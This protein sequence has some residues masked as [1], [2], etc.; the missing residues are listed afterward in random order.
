[1]T[2][3]H[4]LTR[5]RDI[6][7]WVSDRHGIPAIA[8]VRNQFGEERAQLKLSFQKRKKHI[9]SQD[10][11]MSP[12]SWTAWLAEL[13]RQQLALKVDPAADDFELVERRDAN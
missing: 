4:T 9:E 11:G 6:Q 3:L 7:N 12:C 1:M 13:D 8:R 10:D 2:Q 5:H